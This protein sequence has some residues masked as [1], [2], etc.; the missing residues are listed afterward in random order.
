MGGYLARWRNSDHAADVLL[1][2][3]VGAFV[4]AVRASAS[5]CNAPL[6]LICPPHSPDVYASECS[7]QAH[8]RAH[9][10]LEDQLQS[11]SN[12]FL[13]GP[14]TLLRACESLTDYYCPFLDRVAHS[15]YSPLALSAIAG[16]AVRQVIL[17]IASVLIC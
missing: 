6:L 3:A 13:S 2:D 1:T 14:A 15:P 9:A 17:I 12:V 10:L 11:L 16:F 8:S 5:L 4:S 7:A